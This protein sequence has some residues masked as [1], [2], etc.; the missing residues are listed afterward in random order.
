MKN[1]RKYFTLF[2]AALIMC[3]TCTSCLTNQVFFDDDEWSYGELGIDD[4]SLLNSEIEID[5]LER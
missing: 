5:D 4:Q 2:F 3:L 1:A